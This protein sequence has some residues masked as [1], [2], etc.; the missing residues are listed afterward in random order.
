MTG[1]L[2]LSTVAVVLVSSLI[3]PPMAWASDLPD[4]RGSA[5]GVRRGGTLPPVE[6]RLLD[7]FAAQGLIDSLKAIRADTN[8]H[9]TIAGLV[10][11]IPRP[12]PRGTG[13]AADYAWR[14]ARVA[15]AAV[16]ALDEVHLTGYHPADAIEPQT[17][18]FT[19]A[20]SRAEAAREPGA[21]SRI[22]SDDRPSEGRSAFPSL[23]ARKERGPRAIGEIPAGVHR[24]SVLSHGDPSKPTLALTFD[25]GPGPI[26]TTLLLDTLDQ[27]GLKATFFLVGERVI[28]YPYFVQA[29]AQRGHDVGNHS[30][31][32]PNLTRLT[33]ADV[34]TELAQTQE[35]I[36]RTVG[37]T[38]RYFRPPG[39]DYN[40]SIIAAARSLGLTTVLWTDD[41]GDYAHLDPGLVEQR[42]MSRTHNG[43][44]LLLHQGVSDTVHILPPIAA[45]L[46]REGYHLT[47]VSDLPLP[48]A[49][50]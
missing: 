15:L 35:A 43:G 26:Y 23:R 17:V 8:G 49:G 21:A 18:A 22:W 39:G 13:V 2:A 38:P 44:I 14:L 12:T 4:A 25:D 46:R 11:V 45:L 42:L 9:L 5:G 16:P 10:F 48:A 6:H 32:H 41:P 1:R 40:A 19:A 3:P 7:A 30:F 37:I 27:L 20:V 36:A 31:H 24:E 29:I 47:K 34:L 28:Q 33:E 50:P